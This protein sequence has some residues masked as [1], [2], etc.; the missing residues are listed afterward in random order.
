MTV[1][2]PS[3]LGE[4]SQ[5]IDGKGRMSIPSD[6]RGVLDDG[7]IDRPADKTTRMFLLY[8]PH[9]KNH[10]QAYTPD[11]MLEIIADIKR[12][13]RGSQARKRASK[14]IM[15]KSLQIEIDKDGRIVLPKE[16]REQIGIN[17]KGGMI[18]MIGLGDYFEIWN[19]DVY[20]EIEGVDEEAYLEEQGED[21]DVM[22]LLPNSE[23]A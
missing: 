7:D 14:L 22:S 10:M 16:R 23:G 19:K 9:L 4:F 13:P 2:S 12:L 18:T 6:F 1:A 21:F 17:E 15:G 11:A 8:G 5:K 3:F 20:D